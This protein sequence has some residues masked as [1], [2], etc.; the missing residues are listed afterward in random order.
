MISTASKIPLRVS[1]GE[2]ASFMSRLIVPSSGEFPIE[3]G[4]DVVG[5]SFGVQQ[6]G[7]RHES[8]PLAAVSKFDRFELD[9]WLAKQSSDAWQL[10]LVSGIKSDLS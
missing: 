6:D 4:G 3:S 10:H 1:F 8:P 7:S 5:Y 9:V 2:I